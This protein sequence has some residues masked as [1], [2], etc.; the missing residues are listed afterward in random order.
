MP[1][2]YLEKIE[3]DTLNEARAIVNSNKHYN[4][5]ENGREDRTLE[6]MKEEF[7]N[8]MTKSFL[9]KA[10]N[11]YIGVLDYIDENPKDHYPWLGLLMIHQGYHGKGFGK[12]AYFLYEEEVRKAGIHAVRLGVLTENRAA[13]GFWESLGFVWYETKP[14]KEG[15]EVDCYEKVII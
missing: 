6:E 11:H 9:V 15:K 5:I 2:F 1:H 4:V 10:D 8:P 14:Y 3:I 13:R 12:A 7:L